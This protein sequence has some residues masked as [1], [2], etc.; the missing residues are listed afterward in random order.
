MVLNGAMGVDKYKKVGDSTVHLL[1]FISVLVPINQYFRRLRGDTDRLPYVQGLGQLVLDEHEHLTVAS[2]DMVS[3]FNL[4]RLPASW[5]SYFA[6]EKRVPKSIFGGPPHEYTYV[7][8]QTIPMGWSGAVDVIQTIARHI[9]FDLAGISPSLEFAKGLPLPPKD[10]AVVCLDGFDHIARVKTLIGAVLHEESPQHAAFVQVCTQLGIPLTQGKSVVASGF[11]SVLGADVDGERGILAQGRNKSW[12]MLWKFLYV[13]LEDR[14][15]GTA[16]QHLL[17]LGSFACSFRR[18]CY[19]LFQE[20]YPFLVA[21][22]LD[23]CLELSPAVIDELLSVAILLPLMKTDLRS[24]IRPVLSASDASLSGGGA[25]EARQYVSQL[26]LLGCRTADWKLKLLEQSACSSDVSSS[27]AVCA[28]PAVALLQCSKGCSTRF[29]SPD[30][31][32]RHY[33]TCSYQ[34]L[35][36][37]KLVEV[38]APDMS[39]TIA[40]MHAQA[41]ILP[42]LLLCDTPP[43][44]TPQVKEAL[45]TSLNVRDL[46]WEFFWVPAETF[47]KHSGSRALRSKRF[48]FGFPSLH[49][50]TREPVAFANKLASFA[51]RR[52]RWRVLNWGFAAIFHPVSSFLWDLPELQLLARLTGL[53]WDLLCLRCLQGGSGAFWLL[54]NCDSLDVTW[55]HCTCGS[56]RADLA[57]SP[58]SVVI[59]RLAASIHSSVADW[60]ATS[61]P[62]DDI[63]LGMFIS[64]GLTARQRQDNDLDAQAQVRAFIQSAS[65]S[66]PLEHLRFL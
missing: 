22:G 62:M 54:H 35:V 41:H 1:R 49:A 58:Q 31:L 5:K 10:L 2:E 30:C 40:W 63:Q 21:Q 8:I 56:V 6:F 42:P 17:G 16:L 59:G 43:P 32:L 39:L 24:P 50:N 3:C 51:I 14:P 18:P 61:Y 28:K 65:S 53:R 45:F 20:A 12:K 25:A 37:P 9:T 66:S 33:A 13:L 46:A 27:C 36:V 55:A 38:F 26:S 34:N 52:L 29:C 48:P 60:D 44:F 57:S 15:S 11:A 7:A 23:S 64:E 19:S 47:S 4:F